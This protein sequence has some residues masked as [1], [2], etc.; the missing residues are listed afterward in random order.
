MEDQQVNPLDLLMRHV[1]GDDGD[2]GEHDKALN[3]EAIVT[4]E[5]RI[6]SAY[7]LVSGDRIWVITEWDRSVTTILLP[8]DY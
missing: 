3:A 5:S 1:S 7:S 4:G 8:D 2:L 6:F